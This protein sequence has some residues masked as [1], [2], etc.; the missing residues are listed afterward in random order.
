M[1]F[2]SDWHCIH[3]QP[4]DSYLESNSF[5]ELK[6]VSRHCIMLGQ[7]VAI[8]WSAGN[9]LNKNYITLFNIEVRDVKINKC[10]DWQTWLIQVINIASPTQTQSE[11]RIFF[12]A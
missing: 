1:H 6:H 5:I 12:V 8:S 10:L 2:I 11:E 7:K 4:I 3:V 9:V